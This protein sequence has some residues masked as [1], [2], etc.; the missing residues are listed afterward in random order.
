MSG[1]DIYL[2]SYME[3]AWK[4]G[5]YKRWFTKLHNEIMRSKKMSWVEKSTLFPIF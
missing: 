3:G 4:E 5:I 2:T 1:Q